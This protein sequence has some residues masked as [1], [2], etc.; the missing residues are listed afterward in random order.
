MLRDSVDKAPVPQ[1]LEALRLPPPVATYP[2]ATFQHA[3]GN[4]E[5]QDYQMQLMLLE[6]QNKKRLLMARQEQ[7][8]V[9]PA[10]NSSAMAVEAVTSAPDGAVPTTGKSNG[11]DDQMSKTDL[12]GVLDGADASQ[13][14]L[15]KLQDYIKLLQLKA[16][17]YERTEKEKAPSRYQIIFR[18]KRMETVHDRKGSTKFEQYLPFFD[19]PEWVKGQGTNRIQS[20]LPLSNFELY[21]ER[22]KDVAFIVYRNFDTDSPRIVAKPRTNNDDASERLVHLPQYTSETIRPVEKSLIEAIKTL[23]GSKQ[24]YADILRELSTTFE[25]AAPYLFIYY[26]RKSLKLFLDSLP[27]IA[28]PQLSLLSDFV[29]EE[30]GDE[31]SAADSLLSQGKISPEHVRYLFKPGDLLVSRV[32]GQYM[33]YVSTSWPKISYDKQVSPMRA[34]SSGNGTALSLYGSQDAEAR[35]ATKKVTVNVCRVSVWH[36][37][38]DGNFQRI[39]KLLELAHPAIEDGKNA[40]DI[41]GKGMAATQGKEYKRGLGEKNISDLNIF[42]MRFAPAEIVDKCRRRGKTFWKCRT[43][44]FVSY[45]DSGMES[46]QNLV[47]DSVIITLVE[48]ISDQF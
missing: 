15:Q 19:H 30:Y 40:A 22:N 3:R 24:E 23:L 13:L 47:S 9:N 1:R 11:L 27:L 46:I 28:K 33:G 26:S 2:V 48:R 20:N 35:M 38:F 5:L 39:H 37:D 32:D 25:L 34:T 45:R 16:Q 41:K 21:L 18:I 12:Q 6:Q 36:W 43:R 8:L 42:P 4:H 14:D 29:T 7:D 10:G 44:N 17:E 31:Y